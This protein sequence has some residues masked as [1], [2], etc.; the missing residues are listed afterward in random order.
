MKTTTTTTAAV[1]WASSE[2]VCDA[3]KQP[4]EIER[5][6]G[7]EKQLTLLNYDYIVALL[8]KDT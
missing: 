1:V 3:N 7:R 2:R 4:N 5:E 6:R 8:Y